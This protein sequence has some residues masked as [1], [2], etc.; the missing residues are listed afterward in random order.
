MKN[1]GNH[2]ISWAAPIVPSV[3]MAGIELGQSVD[4][5]VDLL[6]FYA[7]D[8]SNN[9]FKFEMSPVLQL[10]RSKSGDGEIFLFS[11]Y[12]RELTNWRLYFD[13][14]D[15]SG[16]NPRAL[17][18]V[19]HAGEVHSVK[20]WHFEKLKDG[21]K[22]RNI[23]SGKLMEHIGLGDFVGDLLPYVTL[24]YDDAEEWFYAD[25]EFEGLEVTGYGTLEEYPDQ[26]I[27]AI[28][29]CRTR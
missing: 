3:S 17:A 14:P 24:S 23:Y 26:I 16:A 5:L 10:R 28:S 1:V 21:D 20:A 29:V 9:L 11:V 25:G 22:P 12:D 15:H 7:V 18:I 2:V 6:S 19:V 8:V 4:E 13:S 27:M